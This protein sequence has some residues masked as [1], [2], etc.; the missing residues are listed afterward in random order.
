ML[1]PYINE[2][3]TDFSKP[4][5]RAAF[6]EALRRVKAE[7]GKTYPLVIDGEVIS[8]SETF[9]SVNPSRP[10]EA[11]GHFAQARAMM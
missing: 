4:E 5:N 2:A 11:V 6:E 3:L 10:A 7:Q 1:P 8:S 9:A